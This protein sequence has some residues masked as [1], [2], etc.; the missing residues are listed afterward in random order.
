M[1]IFGFV[2]YCLFY[3]CENFHIYYFLY[4]DKFTMSYLKKKSKDTSI[5]SLQIYLIL[6]QDGRLR[7]IIRQFLPYSWP[8]SS[9][10][11]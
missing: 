1:G 9:T 6:L 10:L 8:K 11:L 3:L 7:Y 2:T 4:S 5:F